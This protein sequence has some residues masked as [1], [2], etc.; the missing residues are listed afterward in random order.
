MKQAICKS[1]ERSQ[2]GP[3][4]GARQGG[5]RRGLTLYDERGR[6]LLGCALDEVVQLVHEPRIG[7]RVEVRCIAAEGARRGGRLVIES[8]HGADF[9]GEGDQRGHGDGKGA[10]RGA[11][12]GLHAYARGLWAT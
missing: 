4:F 7:A 6:M 8:R 3:R 10:R 2:F 5:G 1:G 11:F 9:I 12:G